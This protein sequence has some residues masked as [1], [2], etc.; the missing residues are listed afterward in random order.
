MFTE[1]PVDSADESNVS[2]KLG[3]EYRFDDSTMLYGSL[4]RGYRG[5]AFNGQAQFS[6]EEATYAD[7]ETVDAI[8]AGLKTEPF[9]G[10]ARLNLS[11]FYYRYENQQ[12]IDT[13]PTLSLVLANAPESRVYGGEI[14]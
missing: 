8:E 13:T 14:E 11:A 4:S 9:G 1:P 6:A 2:G 3:F 5:G 10:A 7:P 12:Y